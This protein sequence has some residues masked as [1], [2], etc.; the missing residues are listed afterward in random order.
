MPEHD[1]QRERAAKAVDMAAHEEVRNECRTEWRRA[2]AFVAGIDP[3]CLC[4]LLAIR[5]ES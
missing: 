4:W 1:A 3:A 2:Q 5:A